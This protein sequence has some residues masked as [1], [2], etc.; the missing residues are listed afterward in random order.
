[1]RSLVA[2]VFSLCLVLNAVNAA[3][4]DVCDA[5]KAGDNAEVSVSSTHDGHLGHHVHDHASTPDTDAKSGPAGSDTQPFH[6]DHCHPHQCFTM[7][8]PG[9]LTMPAP[10]G[11]QLLP[12]AAAGV[13]FSQPLSRIERPPQATLA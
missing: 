6:G 13:F 11:R 8:V 9:Q 4:V 12:L 7:V 2:F 3:A 10:T 5:L 1:M